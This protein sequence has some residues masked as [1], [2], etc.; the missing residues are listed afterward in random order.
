MPSFLRSLFAPSLDAKPPRFS[1]GVVLGVVLVH[2]LLLWGLF[3]LRVIPVPEAA[4]T[5]MVHF[6]APSAVVLPPAPKPTAPTPPPPN[7]PVKP[8]AP[9]EAKPIAQP[10]S[11]QVVA[12]APVV[13]PEDALASA[14]A[15]SKPIISE[16]V[17]VPAL[18]VGPVALS[19][20]LSVVCPSRRAPAYPA[21]SR[22]LGET[23]KVVLRVSLD[24]AGNVAKA[25]VDRSSGFPRLDEAAL[26]AVRDWRCTPALRNGQAVEATALQPFN[27]VL[28][29]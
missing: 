6:V 21:L 20:D 15:P 12:E 24:K 16:P 26:T 4:R 3:A 29:G 28:E 17:A 10:V 2:G 9:V 19:G 22:R 13:L 11:P 8:P 5:V 1:W 25:S 27:F 14:P 7:P 23:G 18:P